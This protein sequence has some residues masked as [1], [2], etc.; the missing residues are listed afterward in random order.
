MRQADLEAYLDEALPPEE[1]ARIE[2]ALRDRPELR[3]RLAAINARRDTGV[4]SLGAIWRR[5]R[6]S[7]LRPR[8]VG[9]LPARHASAG[10]GGLRLPS[11]WKRWGAAAVRRIWP[12]WKSSR[13]KSL[14]VAATRP[15]QIL[16]VQC[17]LSAAGLAGE[18][19]SGQWGLGCR[20]LVPAPNSLAFRT[21]RIA[22]TALASPA[23]ASPLGGASVLGRR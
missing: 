12:T 7:C 4:H 2:Q 17:R 5:H 19:V 18:V 20:L 11:T 9:Q 8:A 21:M 1:M 23:L 15:T 22:V 3:E 13:R 14:R 16:P 10:G 6:L